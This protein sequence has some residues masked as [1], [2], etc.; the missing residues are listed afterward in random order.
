MQQQN[1][2][3]TAATPRECDS[4][5]LDKLGTGWIADDV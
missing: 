4:A 2:F 5:R 3:A 1:L